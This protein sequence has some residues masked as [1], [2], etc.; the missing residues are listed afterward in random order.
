MDA[1]SPNRRNGGPN[2]NSRDTVFWKVAVLP[3]GIPAIRRGQQFVPEVTSWEARSESISEFSTLRLEA[4]TAVPRTLFLDLFPEDALGTG[5]SASCTDRLTRL[6]ELSQRQ[7]SRSRA[8]GP[9]HGE[10]R[11][12]LEFRGALTNRPQQRGASRLRDE[13]LTP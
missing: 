3:S 8:L 1:L 5:I 11:S 6:R 13:G 7:E 4:V 12:R 9:V 2:L 10:N